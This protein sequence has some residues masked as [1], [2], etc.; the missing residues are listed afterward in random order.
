MR[1]CIRDLG[2][3]IEEDDEKITITGFGRNPKD[4]KELDVG[5]AGAVLRFLWQSLRFARKL[6]S[7]TVIQIRSANVRMTI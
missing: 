4:V 5:N 7:S 3:V 1:R 6:R 2:A